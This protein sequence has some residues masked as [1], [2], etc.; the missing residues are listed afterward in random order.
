MNTQEN[1]TKIS[2]KEAILN[3]RMLNCIFNGLTAG[4]PIYFLVNLI[5]AWLRSEGVDLKTI[6]FFGFVLLPYSFK[7]LW[8]P[9]LDCYTP[10]FLGRRRGWML[11]TQVVIMFGMFANAFL[12]V[13][14]QIDFILYA[15]L[16]VAI[17]SATQDIVLDAYRR[18]LL[19]DEEL[20]LGNSYY[21]NAYRLSAFIPGSLGLILS[22]SIAWKYVF[23]IIGLFMFIGIIYSFV[24]S[25]TDTDVVPPKNLVEAVVDPFKEFFLRD[26]F[27]SGF[28]ILFFILFYK[29]GD[30]VATSLITPFYIDVGFSNSIIGTVTKVVGFWSM[31]IGGF[32]GGAIMFKTGINK[33]LWIFGVVQMVSILGFAALNEVG[34]NITLLGVVVAFEYLGV[35]LGSAALMAYIAKNTNK[36][37]TGTQLA[38]LTSLFAIPKSFSGIISGIMI[39]G[40]SVKD[41][42]LYS[43]LGLTKGIGYTNYFV[44]CTFLAIPGMLL[45]FKVAPWSK[46]AEDINL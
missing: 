37:F 16:A 31:V 11:I 29:F 4:L 10:P 41:E 39:E 42:F 6:G 15:G 5:P 8:A 33:A 45:L 19:P 22:D 2:L 7:F 26:G 34:A 18:E 14:T 20:G 30:T 1:K 3:K 44:V 23:I 38:L 28:F 27:K 21:A 17:F 13:K 9:L 25:D 43:I 24:V 12:D 46:S 36:N 35:G 32:V 40:V